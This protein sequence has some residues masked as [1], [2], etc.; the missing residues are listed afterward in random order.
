MARTCADAWFIP[1]RNVYVYN[2]IIYNPSNTFTGWQHFNIG[3][4]VTPPACS[5]IPNPSRADEGLQIRGNLIWSGSSATPLG[6]EGAGACGPGNPDCN[7]AQLRADNMINVMQPQLR[8]PEAGDFRPVPC[9]NVF[10]ARTFAIPSFPGNDR[11]QPPLAPAGDLGNAVPRDKNA[12]P[13]YAELPPGAFTGGAGFRLT[14]IARA[15]SLSQITLAAETGHHYAVEASTNLASWI[16]LAET[17]NA[18]AINLFSLTATNAF[19][20]FRGRLLP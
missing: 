2:N 13:R 15:G 1:N 7:E 9:G 6:I 18:A 8:D 5:N 14:D 11:V 12:N 20:A 16:S 10:T 17:S 4:P 3:E 19:R